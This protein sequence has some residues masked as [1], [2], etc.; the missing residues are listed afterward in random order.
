MNSDF[1]VMILWVGEVKKKSL[2]DIPVHGN[3]M[4]GMAL[5][6]Q[7]PGAAKSFGRDLICISK[8]AP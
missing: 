1:I 7:K 5:I 3:D 2:L 4:D 6:P 8:F